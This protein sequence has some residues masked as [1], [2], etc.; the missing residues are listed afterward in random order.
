MTEMSLPNDPTA[1]M[2]RLMQAMSESLTDSMVERLS[3]TAA[4]GL[5][6]V[7]KLNDEDTRE[8]VLALIDRLTELHRTGALDTMFQ[9]L[10]LIHGC[11]EAMTDSMVER[12]FAFVE[13]MMNNLANE[14]MADLAH[15]AKEAMKH[16][17]DE[18]A[19]HQSSGG[20]FATLSML[21]Q[22]ESQ[23]ALQFMMA[24]ACKMRSLSVEEE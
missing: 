14:E 18:A 22:P 23:Q 2:S 12:L 6:V 11:R 10:T 9:L 24:F 17:S 8:A 4:N 16:A 3:I 15:N 19:S 13:H 1:D 7:D 20:L 5:E 21:S